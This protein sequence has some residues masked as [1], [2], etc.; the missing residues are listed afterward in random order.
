M[1][2]RQLNGVTQHDAYPI[3]RIDDSLDALAG[4]HYF[5]TLDLTN[6]YWQVPLDQNAG[7]KSTFRTQSGLWQ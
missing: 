1:D 7:E 2:Y 5:S 3:L 4:S 6:E